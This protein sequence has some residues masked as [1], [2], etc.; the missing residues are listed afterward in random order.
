VAIKGD[1]AIQLRE[2]NLLREE[3]VTFLEFSLRS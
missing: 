1:A 3:V 2:D